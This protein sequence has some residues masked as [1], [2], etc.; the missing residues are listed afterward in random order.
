MVPLPSLSWSAGSPDVAM[1]Q[2][3][4]AVTSMNWCDGFDLHVVVRMNLA[5]TYFAAYGFD[6]RLDVLVHTPPVHAC[7]GSSA[8]GFEALG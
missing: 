5:V 8:Q 2:G 7:E 1:E 3:I 6:K 4:S